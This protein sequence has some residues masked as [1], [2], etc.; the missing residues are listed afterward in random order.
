M[1][2]AAR[3][4]EYSV[5]RGMLQRCRNPNDVAYAAYGGRGIYVCPRWHAFACFIEDLGPRP[6][7]KHSVDRIDNDGPYACGKCPHCLERGQ[8]PN[9]RWATK[10]VQQNN[11]RAN[12][13]IM[14]RGLNLTAPQWSRR[15]GI[16]ESTIRMRL[17]A[18]HTL[19]QVFSGR[20]LDW[21][22]GRVRRAKPKPEA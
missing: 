20:R 14:W 12:R 2:N 13:R 5:W 19:E 7:P 18:G 9:A 15:T 4:P 16:N 11:T 10:R 8:A 22:G 6:S 1:K 17:L 21:T 3:V